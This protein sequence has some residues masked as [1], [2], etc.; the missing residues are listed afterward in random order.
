MTMRHHMSC[1]MYIANT[2]DRIT[3]SN[4]QSLEIDLLCVRE[5]FCVCLFK[6]RVG[7]SQAVMSIT[8]EVRLSITAVEKAHTQTSIYCNRSWVTFNTSVYTI[9]HCWACVLPYVIIFSFPALKVREMPGRGPNSLQMCVCVHLH[10][11][12]LILNT[13]YIFLPSLSSPFPVFLHISA[14]YRVAKPGAEDM[15]GILLF[16]SYSSQV[17]F[18]SI[19]YFTKPCI[20]STFILLCFNVCTKCKT[21]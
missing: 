12:S 21:C 11:N 3:L 7:F 16:S 13:A 20:S 1:H 4:T 17:I 10:S 18:P 9:V 19:Y 15:L 8:E 5:C 2:I 14:I 6:C